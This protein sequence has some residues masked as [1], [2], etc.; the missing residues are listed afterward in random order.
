[1]TTWQTSGIGAYFSA[2]IYR[3]WCNALCSTRN[4]QITSNTS[5]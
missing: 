1:M 4:A 5:L 3:R 2:L